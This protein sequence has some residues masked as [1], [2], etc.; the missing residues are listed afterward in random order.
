ML[1]VLQEP[2]A[3]KR[4]AVF[5]NGVVS[6][7]KE[8]QQ[9]G[10]SQKL[11]S[12]VEDVPQLQPVDLLV[13]VLVIVQSV[14]GSEEAEEAVHLKAS[15]ADTVRSIKDRAA[16]AELIPFPDQDLLLD[17]Q[18]LDDASRLADCGVTTGASLRMVVRAS[19]EALVAQLAGLLQNRTM[20]ATELSQLYCYRYGTN[21]SRAMK[22]VGAGKVFKE[23]LN[24]HH[25]F[26]VHKGCVTLA[27][28]EPAGGPPSSCWS[29]SQPTAALG[30]TM[31]R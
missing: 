27:E 28:V 22:L 16:A 24:K 2:A 7:V 10:T 5:G 1:D 11:A 13:T 26:C 8:D 3:A 21:V 23:F 12:I 31:C 29:W 18:P 25:A 20:S 6:R 17:G 15:P 9:G 30:T 4:F 19:E 14:C